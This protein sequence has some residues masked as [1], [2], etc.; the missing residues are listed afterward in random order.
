MGG[1]SGIFAQKNTIAPNLLR[2]YRNTGEQL[3][4]FGLH[5]K[6]SKQ[7]QNQQSKCQIH[8]ESSYSIPSIKIKTIQIYLVVCQCYNCSESS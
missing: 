3:S 6:S 1:N 2:N 5:L 8:F 4:I 7:I